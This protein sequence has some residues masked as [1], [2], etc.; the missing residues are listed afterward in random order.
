MARVSTAGQNQLLIVDVLRQQ[1][2]LFDTQKQVTS[3]TKSREYQ[4][5]AADVATLSGAKTVRSRGEQ[6]LKTNLEL[7]RVTEVQNL[8]LQ[9]LVD[10]ADDVRETLIKAMNVGSGIGLRDTIDALFDAAVNFLNVQENG[11]FVFG[12]TRTDVEPLTVRTPADLEALGAGNAANAFVNNQIKAQARVDESLTVTYGVLADEV[13][14]PLMQLMQDLMIYASGTPSAFSNPLSSADRAFIISK[15]PEA[16][17]AFDV[18]NGAQAQH[19]VAM[20][21]I[22]DAQ[23]RH[24]NEL[25]FINRFIAN[26][27]DTDIA[28][29]VTKL[30]QDQLALES[31]FRV[32]SQL[33]SLSLLN[34]I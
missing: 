11:R 19:G 25:A 33:N 18:A 2:R 9:G 17:A 15:I 26:I 13:A 6:F 4:G 24:E 22:E 10:V 34:F 3:G 16:N 1:E 29:A 12:G 21:T 23:I 8:S 31:S 28:E 30:N 7:E 27:E 14:G 5:I 32:F 20:K